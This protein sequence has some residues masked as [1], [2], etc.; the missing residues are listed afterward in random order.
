[1]QYRATLTF[2]ILHSLAVQ[3]FSEKS[4]IYLLNLLLAEPEACIDIFMIVAYMHLAGN[5]LYIS[6]TALYFLFQYTHTLFTTS[7]QYAFFMKR[8]A[9]IAW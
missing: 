9:A 6:D 4:S 5:D 7:M 3:N 2:N 8:T 1:M